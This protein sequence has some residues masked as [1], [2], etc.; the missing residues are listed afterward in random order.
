MSLTAK[1]LPFS[2]KK[3]AK[4]SII[5]WSPPNLVSYWGFIRQPPTHKPAETG[6]IR[7]K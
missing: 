3:Y 6:I 5:T 2:E 7:K 1:L 4:R